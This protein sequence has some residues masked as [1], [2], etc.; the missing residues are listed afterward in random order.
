MTSVEIA[1]TFSLRN[2]RDIPS[3]SNSK[4]LA[5]TAELKFEFMSAIS[6]F[7]AIL[8]RKENGINNIDL[9]LTDRH[10][11]TSPM[12]HQSGA[13]FASVQSFPKEQCYRAGVFFF[14]S[15]PTPLSFFHPC[16]YPKGYYFYSPQSSTVIKS[17]MVAATIIRIRKRFRPP[18][19]RLHCRLWQAKP[20]SMT[21]NLIQCYQSP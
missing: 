20:C 4:R 16:T 2:T 18:K 5:S 6:E 1:L 8:S 13:S 7:R 21:F 10:Q 3:H 9:H 11:P 19:I 12:P 15:S 14:L 17:K